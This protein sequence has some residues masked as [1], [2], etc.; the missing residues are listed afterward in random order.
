MWHKTWRIK[1]G[2]KDSR[3]EEERKRKA[4]F[5]FYVENYNMEIIIGIL[6]SWVERK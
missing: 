5:I 4:S 2:K 3:V 1:D 6:A